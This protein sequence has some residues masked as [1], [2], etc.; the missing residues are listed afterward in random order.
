MDKVYVLTEYQDDAGWTMS[1]IIG[2]FKS[3]DG[4]K[5]RKNELEKEMGEYYYC[6]GETWLEI[7]AYNIR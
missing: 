3:E 2:I 5:Q 6:P 4:A 7:E 1:H